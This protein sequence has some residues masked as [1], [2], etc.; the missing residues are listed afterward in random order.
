M[1]FA[2]KHLQT[3]IDDVRLFSSYVSDVM[4]FASTYHTNTK[5]DTSYNS[6]WVTTTGRLL[7]QL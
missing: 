1:R 4:C 3:K 6:D 7:G 2:V 5:L